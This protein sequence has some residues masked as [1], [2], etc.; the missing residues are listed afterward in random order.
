MGLIFIALVIVF[1]SSDNDVLTNVI[2][3]IWEYRKKHKQFNSLSRLS[4]PK[5][6][7]STPEMSVKIPF[8]QENC[9]RSQ[10]QG[11]FHATFHLFIAKSLRFQIPAINL[12]DKHT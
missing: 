2:T 9:V 8:A 1:K 4:K 11:V 3:E 5:P 7:V 12:F 10:L 6:N